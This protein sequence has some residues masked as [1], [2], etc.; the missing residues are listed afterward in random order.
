MSKSKPK[1]SPKIKATCCSPNQKRVCFCVEHPLV[2]GYDILWGEEQIEVLQCLCKKPTLH[3]VVQV[4]GIIPH[5]K[6]TAVAPS[7]LAMPLYSLKHFPAP[8]LVLFVSCHAI[9]YHDTLHDLRTKAH[10]A[11]SN[12]QL[13]KELGKT[14][15]MLARNDR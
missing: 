2:K 3:F 8:F 14:K 4:R 1:V 9:H 11:I 7:H 15:H 6:Y 5:V 13:Q 10:G 12:N